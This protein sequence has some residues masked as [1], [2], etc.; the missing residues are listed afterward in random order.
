[1]HVHGAQ[2]FTSSLLSADAS[3]KP[4][5][6]AGTRTVLSDRETVSRRAS[7]I[8]GGPLWPFVSFGTVPGELPLDQL[9]LALDR[10]PP[11]WPLLRADD[12]HVVQAV[13]TRL[14]WAGH[15]RRYMYMCMYIAYTS[16]HVHVHTASM[17]IMC[18]YKYK[19]CTCTCT[20]PVHVCAVCA[21]QALNTAWATQSTVHVHVVI[22]PCTYIHTCII[23]LLV[24]VHVHVSV[25]TW[26]AVS[27]AGKTPSS[28]H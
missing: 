12:V 23:S 15:N 26:E 20:V 25:I 9:V 3:S 7:L 4:R 13:G 21:L 2:Q 24:H 16:I 6:A 5:T 1:M 11:L 19:S 17:Y 22:I 28:P 18:V 8:H 14:E 27:L 10:A